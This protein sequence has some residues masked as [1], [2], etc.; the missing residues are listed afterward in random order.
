MSVG[1]GLGV[2]LSSVSEDLS[3][4]ANPATHPKIKAFYKFKSLGEQDI[5]TVADGGDGVEAWP[6]QTGSFNL[7]QA[8][9]GE[10][11]SYTA[12]TGAVNFNGSNQSLEA[13]TSLS[14]TGS[15][16]VGIRMNVDTSINNDTALGSNKESGNFIRIKSSSKI[17]LRYG[18][19]GLSDLD[20]DSA[21]SDA[22]T[23]N[24]IVSRN[25]S[26]LSKMFFNGTEQS[27]TKTEGTP[28]TF[29]FDTLGVRRIDSNDLDGAIFEV[30]IYDGIDFNEPGFISALNTHLSNLS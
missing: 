7:A 14:L 19:G 15:F 5:D 20:L 1:L 2:T 26:G 29:I 3:F 8:D 17:G 23:F 24:L 12:S 9:D 22:T 11:P 4:R 28:S 13:A 16:I 18:G 21:I 25:N 6:D 10:R 30:Q 27:N